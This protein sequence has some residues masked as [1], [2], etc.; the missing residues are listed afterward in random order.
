MSLK[1]GLEAALGRGLAATERL[2]LAVSGGPDSMALLAL[3]ATEFPGRIAAL[4][5]DHRLRPAAATEA[6]TVA[7]CCVERG[8]PHATLAWR[9][10]KPATGIQSA[11]RE[12]RYTLMAEWCAANGYTLLL[13]AHHADD[14]AETLLMRLARGSGSAGLAGIRPT[15]ALGHGVTL[16]RP[17]LSRRRAELAAIASAT[18]WPLADDP[19]N[20]DP[21]YSRTAARALLAATPWLD[22]PNIAA[23]AAHLA[24]AEAALAWAADRAWAGRATC[25]PTHVILDTAGLPAELVRRLVLQALA[26]LA[27]A[28]QPRGPDLARLI[29]RLTTGG[30][31]TLAGIRV[32]GGPTWLFSPAAPR[33]ATIPAPKRT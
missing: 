6:A 20:R 25:T 29:A 3:A 12:A 32:T 7:A 31:A 1:A 4:T 13:T 17:L 24:A 18:G 21:H 22:V 30:T 5:V 28:A 16:V 19:S 27:P 8:I 26:S 2:A 14:Q 9:G 23:T 10:D 15:R 33:N 11:A